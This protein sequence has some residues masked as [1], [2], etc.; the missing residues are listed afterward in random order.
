[1]AETRRL[2]VALGPVDAA[3]TGSALAG[4]LR[5]LGVEAELA[6]VFSHPFGYAADRVLDR[7]ARVSYALRLPLARDV[8]HLQFGRSFLPGLAD[9]AWAR[10]AG[11][12]LV[13]SLYGDDCRLYGPAQRLFPPRGRVG[14]ASGDP[15]VRSRLRR[16]GRLCHAALVGDLELATYAAPFFDRLY[17][18][19]VPVHETVEP[20]ERPRSP[21]RPLV[22][23]HA[24]SDPVVK[25]SAAVSAAVEAVAARRPVEYRLLT[26]VPHAEVELAHAEADVVVDQ[27]N[28]VTPGIVAYEAMRRGLPVL[29]ELDPGALAPFGREAPIVRVTAETLADEL[30]ALVDDP[31]RRVA[32]GRRGEAYVARVHA[33]VQVARAALA[34][35]THARTGPPGLYE[36]TA[37]GI[38]ELEPDVLPGRTGAVHPPASVRSARPPRR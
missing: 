25:G 30:T 17:V 24:P 6:V 34:V 3:G 27:L 16:L 29:C 9:A 28:S 1:M 18:T 8:L 31:E 13:V 33:P 22:V 35:Y 26:G 4:G 5:A 10:A 15:A 11:A 20:P 7:R 36:A 2:R 32:L 12:T 37:E 38:R 14:N 21:A 19:P 23:L